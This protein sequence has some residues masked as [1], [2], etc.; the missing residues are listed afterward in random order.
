MTKKLFIFFAFLLF[1]LRSFSQDATKNFE[2]L[3]PTYKVHN[4]LYNKIGFLDSRSYKAQIGSI[5]IGLL[6]NHD[7]KFVLKEPFE[8]QLR[9]VLS[10]M[11]DSSAQEGELL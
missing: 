4:S 1:F 10:K 11:I 2:L 7:A 9:S 6:K 5:S 3:L 8:N